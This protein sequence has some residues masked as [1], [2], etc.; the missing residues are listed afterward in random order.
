M[1][2]ALYA[3]LRLLHLRGSSSSDLEPVCVCE[4]VLSCYVTSSEFTTRSSSSPEPSGA[5]HAQEPRTGSRQE[6]EQC[7]GELTLALCWVLSEG[8][9]GQSSGSGAVVLDVV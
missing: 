9:L 5:E 4:F 2:V 7:E 1:I 8:Q 6:Q 3:T